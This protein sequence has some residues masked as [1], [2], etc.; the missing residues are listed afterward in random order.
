MSAMVLDQSLDN[1][2]KSN[3]R[4][5]RPRKRV[6]SV[7]AT[8]KAAIVGK[9]KPVTRAAVL[10]ANI[11]I[12][13]GNKINVTN[14]PLDVKDAEIKEL[15]S[16]TIGPIREAT[17][18]YDAKGHSKGMA[19][20]LFSRKGDAPKAVAQYHGRVID[21]KRQMKVELVLDAGQAP[22]L[23]TLSQRVAPGPAGKAD[24]EKK[25]AN[26]TVAAKKKALL[27]RK[28][29]VKKG[30]ANAADLDAQMED[31]NAAAVPTEA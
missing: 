31:Y 22:A 19:T 26:G 29:R 24:T 3:K 11:H 7:S 27:R 25:P 28:T 23:P 13:T 6:S 20:V 18:H 8:K 5:T 10:A 14:L 12:P 15:F 4:T 2:I 17:L 16:T 30:P 1:I 9:A 21:G